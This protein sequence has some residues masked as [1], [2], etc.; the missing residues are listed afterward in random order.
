MDLIRGID[1]SAVKQTI[2]RNMLQLLKD[3]GITP[4]AREW[5]LSRS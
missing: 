5:R 2:L 4:S 1:R 3:L